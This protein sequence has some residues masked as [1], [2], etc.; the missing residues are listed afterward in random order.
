M[1]GMTKYQ[2]FLCAVRLRIETLGR[3]LRKIRLRPKLEEIKS[4]LAKAVRGMDA[5]RRGFQNKRISFSPEWK[6][7]LNKSAVIA[8][9]AFL[10][11][12]IVL[13]TSRNIQKF[14]KETAEKVNQYMVGIATEKAQSVE[15]FVEEIQDYLALLARKP[16]SGEFKGGQPLPYNAYAAGEALLAHLG[17]RVDSI[18]R[19]DNKGRLLH[20][21]PATKNGIGKDFSKLPGVKWVLQNRSPYVSDVFEISSGIFGFHICQPVFDGKSLLGVL[22]VLIRLD[23]LNES[24]CHMQSSPTGSLWIINDKGVIMAHSNPDLIGRDILEVESSASPEVNWSEFQQLVRRMI[25]GE[26]GNGV[27]QAV[28]QN[29]KKKEKIKRAVAFLPIR[30][31]NQVWSIAMMT[32]YEEIAGPV[33]KNTRNSFIGAFLMMLILGVVGIAYY[34]NQQRKAELE[35]VARWAEDLRISNEKLTYEIRQRN[36]AERAREQSENNYQL[37]AENVHDIIWI[38]NLDFRF[39]YISPSVNRV[40]GIHPDD[41]TGQSLE[42]VLSPATLEAA[43]TVLQ[44]DRMPKGSGQD[45]ETVRTID[46]EIH[47]KDGATIRAETK[48][49]LLYDFKG[50]LTG[51]MGVTRDITEKRKLQQQFFQAQKMESIGTLAGGIAHDFNNLLG[52]ILG[53][54]SLLKTKVNENEQ[55]YGFADTIEKSAN[56]AAELTAQLLAFARG[57]KYEP[58]VVSLN[59]IVKESLEIIGRTF[60]KLITVD[61]DLDDAISTV[62]ADTGQIQQVLINLCVNARDAMPAGGTLTIST[63]ERTLTAEEARNRSGARPGRYVVLSVSDTGTGIDRETLQRIFEPFFTTK[64]KGKGTGLGLSMV[65][66]VVNNHGGHIHVQS[67]PGAGAAFHIYLPASGKAETREDSGSQIIRGGQE[68]ILVVDDEEV[69]RYLAKDVLESHGYTV[70]LASDGVEAIEEYREKSDSIALV[71]IDMIMPRMGGRETF[72]KLKEINPNVKAL[73]FT[74]YGKNGEAHEIMRN[75]ISDFIQKPFQLDELLY[76]VRDVL[77]KEV[78]VVA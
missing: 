52:G 18:Y 2:E 70:L 51:L 49:S 61:V 28:V 39:T 50:M 56:R 31:N 33:R 76:K 23:A 15:Q 54:A 64:E 55:A 17:G 3:S 12:A 59:S 14:E 8:A 62:E 41:V 1:H 78:Q 47:R 75:G 73:L 35:A 25:S 38:S 11:T 32:N 65:Y 74:G 66:G 24:V 13:W 53:Y 30:L 69:V 42:T 7:L 26:A 21:V 44:K 71:L 60:D 5:F 48:I 45:D 6:A 27:Y 4:T 9:C 37:L 46:V 57:G 72:L 34:R 40:L 67:T 77:D 10:A 20:R 43:K 22:C 16:F 29:E 36:Q 68:S 63:E 19:L 58:K